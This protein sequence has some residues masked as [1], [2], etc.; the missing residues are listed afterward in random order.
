M[1]IV[2]DNVVLIEPNKYDVGEVTITMI[3]ERVLIMSDI[4]YIGDLIKCNIDKLEYVVIQYTTNYEDSYYDS[5]IIVHID[6][7]KEFIKTQD[8]S[9]TKTIE[10]GNDYIIENDYSLVTRRKYKIERKI[11]YTLLE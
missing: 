3:K 1:E 11:I 4:F 8:M 6:K 9:L 7:F 10:N 2:D 5:M